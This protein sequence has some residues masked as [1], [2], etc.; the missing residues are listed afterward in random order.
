MSYA[1]KKFSFPRLSIYSLGV[2]FIF[3]LVFHPAP[4]FPG[5]DRRSAANLGDMMLDDG[6]YL[7]GSTFDDAGDLIKAPFEADWGEAVNTKNI[8][9]GILALGSIPATIYGL[10]NPIRRNLRDM[11]GGT[12]NDLNYAG[13]G[14]TVGGVAMVYGWGA[15]SHNEEARHVAMTGVEGIGLA[16]LVLTQA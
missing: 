15:I 1:L 9:T 3:A 16:S 7:F 10:D 6:Q 8:L 2:I 13:L 11:N 4:A 5:P 14:M 12:A